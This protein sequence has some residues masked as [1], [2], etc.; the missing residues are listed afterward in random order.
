M[1]SAPAQEEKS[2]ESAGDFSTTN[3][4]VEGIDEADLV[5]TD[6]DNI[7]IVAQSA[8]RIVSADRGEL[9]EVT[10]F[11]ID[12]KKNVKEI[13]LDGD[14]LVVIGTR[15][16]YDPVDPVNEGMDEKDRVFYI[17]SKNPPEDT[18]Q[19]DWESIGLFDQNAPE[20]GENG[21]N[22]G[23]FSDDYS[24]ETVYSWLDDVEIEGT[25]SSGDMDKNVNLDD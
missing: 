22:T 3:T 5:K 1:S 12:E 17:L 21:E 13:F 20:E 15:N 11:R 7:Y 14:R 4:Q 19:D 6:G 23:F 8:I 18:T 16:E 9:N 10:V 2:I 24:G 25:E